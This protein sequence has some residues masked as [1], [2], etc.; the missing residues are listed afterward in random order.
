[1]ATTNIL[2]TS[3][4]QQR[5]KSSKWIEIFLWGLCSLPVLHAGLLLSITDPHSPSAIAIH[6]L[7]PIGILGT[8]FIL[9]VAAFLTQGRRRW[10]WIFDAMAM[11]FSIG[12]SVLRIVWEMPVTAPVML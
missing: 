12:F 4:T 7:R 11:L 1:M 3:L 5:V 6:F 8:V 10:T 9:L 2:T